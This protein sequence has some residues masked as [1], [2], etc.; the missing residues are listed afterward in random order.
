MDTWAEPQRWYR[1]ALFLCLKTR[2]PFS[3]AELDQFATLLC[4]ELQ[5]GPWTWKLHLL[6]CPHW[7]IDNR[8]IFIFG[9]VNYPSKFVC[10]CV[11]M[12]LAYV[13]CVCV[14]VCR[15]FCKGL[16]KKSDDSAVLDSQV[17]F[18]TLAHGYSAAA[19]QYGEPQHKRLIQRC[20]LFQVTNFFILFGS[21]HLRVVH[22]NV[23]RSLLH[24][25]LVKTKTDSGS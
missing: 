7:W 16:L 11:C 25:F 17:P 13:A 10:A 23:A 19:F 12:L 21:L 9:G 18:Q 8:W 5:K 1:G 2:P 20:V 24:L 22:S 3:S 4:L 6:L 15:A 14:C